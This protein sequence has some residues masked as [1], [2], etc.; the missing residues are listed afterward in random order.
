[1]NTYTLDNISEI[2]KIIIETL[3]S[4]NVLFYG[5]MGV[6]KTTL[7]K[8]IARQLGVKEMLNSPSFALVNVYD[9]GEDKLNHFDFY[10]INDEN[11]ALDI[12][13][14]E[15]FYSGHWNFIEWPEKIP[16]LLPLDST[17]IHIQLNNNNSRTI[18][19]T[20]AEEKH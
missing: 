6:G 17:S 7:I 5:K 15:Y 2:A 10:R 16:N 11:E 13:I 4:K 14:E 3:S 8:E 12:G 1:M 20:A 9:I 19:I 18:K